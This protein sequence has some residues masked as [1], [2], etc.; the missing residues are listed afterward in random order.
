VTARSGL[1]YTGGEFKGV[2]S[3]PGQAL[4]VGANKMVF[5]NVIRTPRGIGWT[6]NS[7]VAIQSSGLYAM[8][9]S[10]KVP[11]SSGNSF[12]IA[13]GPSSGY[14]AGDGMYSPEDF[15]YNTTDLVNGI[16]S[17]WLDAGATVSAY[18]YNNSGAVNMN[19][20]RPALFRIWKV[21]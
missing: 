17:I 6:S 1:S 10:C 7:D 14:I 12:G 9:A 2:T 19:T 5:P 4:A 16:P 3:A 8:V 15:G 11:F 18:C 21:G 13:F 20:A